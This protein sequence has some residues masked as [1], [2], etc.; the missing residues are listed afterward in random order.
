[1]RLPLKNACDTSQCLVVDMWSNDGSDI[2]IILI[3][4]AASLIVNNHVVQDNASMH[5]QPKSVLRVRSADD[6]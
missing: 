5:Y 2:V 6:D 1:M 3:V 4:V